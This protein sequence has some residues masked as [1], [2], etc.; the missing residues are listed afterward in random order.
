MTVTHRGVWRPEDRAAS[1]YVYLPVEVGA[2]QRSL[3][4][5]L[6][7][8]R[9][10]DGVL[11]LGC[12]GPDG[13]FRGWSGGARAE[14][15]ISEAWATPGYLPGTVQ[16]GTWQ[17]ILG[18]H[19]VPTDGVAWQVV[20][21]TGRE[22]T[23]RAQPVPPM[24]WPD[25]AGRALP[26]PHGYRWL[27]GDLHAHTVH[28]DGT[29][30]V[31]ELAR[32]AADSGLDF[33]AVTDHNT[34]SHHRELSDVSGILLVPGQEVTTDRGHA[35]AFGAIGWVDFRQPADAWLS[36]VNADGGLMSVNH[37]LGG[38]CAWRQ[39]LTARPPLAEV[40]HSGW[41]DRTWGAPLA[42][43][44]A[45]DAWEGRPTVPVGGSDFHD[46]AQGRL[47]GEPTTWTLCPVTDPREASVEQVL[48]ALAAGR[49][50]VTASPT[51]PGLLRLDEELIAVDAEGLLLA[52]VSGQRRLVRS[53]LARFPAGV[54]PY[55]L[56]DDRTQVMA[57]AP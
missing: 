27:A 37:P 6:E 47:P 35:N 24:D 4:V 13:A 44:L 3:T 23:S 20:A 2:G 15:T 53:P 26:A 54:G 52:D 19:R 1:R 41:W 48:D 18:L 30:T 16:P 32:L 43:L 42:W 34:V 40:W 11:D 49:V 14:F 50:A 33:L 56:E 31:P 55:W 25:R 46:P 17:V 36:A 28:S 38:D 21:S 9:S 29:L 12:L 39:P 7:Y 22:P 45:W 8:D 5:R 51:G 57:L 10:T